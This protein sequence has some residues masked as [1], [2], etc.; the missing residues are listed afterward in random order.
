[1]RLPRD[2]SGEE[3]V[4]ALRV[5]GYETTRQSG[6]HVRLTTQEGKEQHVTIPVHDPLRLGTLSGVLA[7]VA[8]HRGSTK[9]AV[10][11][12]LFGR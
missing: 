4:R 10:L 2:V 5:L 9:E 12:A 11:E 6:S 3:L 1:M 7:E 8:R